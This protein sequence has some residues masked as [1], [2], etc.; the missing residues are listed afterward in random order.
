MVFTYRSDSSHLSDHQLITY[1]FAASN[2]IKPPK[3]LKINPYS[4]KNPKMFAIFNKWLKKLLSSEFDEKMWCNLKTKMVKHNLRFGS[5]EKRASEAQLKLAKSHFAHLN[6]NKL[7]AI[8]K[9]W[10]TNW[11]NTQNL[12]NKYHSIITK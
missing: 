4:I 5:R 11:I 1:E 8:S 7:H 10:E 9:N 2:Y 3:W 6:N 12:I